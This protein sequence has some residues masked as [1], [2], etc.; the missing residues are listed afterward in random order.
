[1]SEEGGR[2]GGLTVLDREDQR[3]KPPKLYHVIVLNDDFTP[4]DFVERTLCEVFKLSTEQAQQ[5]TI[6]IHTKGK[7]I[8]GA[9]PR[10][11]AEAKARQVVD[12]AQVKEFPLMAVS[13]PAP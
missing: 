10:D 6:E 12:R 9:L 4:F 13:E 8:C 2:G 3:V 7:T 5:R 1:M 11:I